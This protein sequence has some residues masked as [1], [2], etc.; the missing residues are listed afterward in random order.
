MYNTF[1]AFT[2]TG[3]H[4]HIWIRDLYPVRNKNLGGL[5]VY[6]FGTSEAIYYVDGLDKGA[7]G[8]W[9]HAILNLDATTRPAA[10][11]GTAPSTDITRVGYVGNISATLGETFTHNAYYCAI[12]RGTAGQGITFTGGTSGDRLTIFNCIAADVTSYGLLR[13]VNGEAFVEGCITFGA[14]AATT[15]L[16]DNLKTVTFK[17]FEVANG[18]SGG[19]TVPAVA[20]DYYRIVLADGTTGITDIRLTDIVWNGFSRAIP[21]S[22]NASALAT[23]DAYVS[24]RSTYLFGSTITLNA[25]CTSTND[26]FVE[27]VTIVPGG[28]TLTNPTFSNCDAIT[29]TATNDALSGGTINKHNTAVNVAFILTNSL[30]KISNTTF[31]NTAGAGHAI[32]IN[33]IGTYTF[34]GNT[35]TGYGAD[36]SSS[37]AIYNNSGG[38]V[39][40]N[41]GGGG[42]TPTIRNGTGASTT[43][44][45]TT[46]VTFA[47]I[48]DNTECR[49]YNKAT[50]VEIAGIE[51]ATAG[52]TDNR[53]F[54]WSA[55]VGLEV[56]YMLHNFSDT[57]PDY[58]NVTVIS[59]I[60]PASAT[61]ID[62]AQA[63]DRN[64]V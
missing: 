2:R 19:T 37:A 11:L 40:I 57:G 44:N 18:T 56:S 63:V 8:A 64:S 23:G 5:S 41:V 50:G 58:Q 42:G 38:L 9:T 25:L 53:T 21:F 46:T 55:A 20:S 51:N 32:E 16:Q 24:L 1:T 7:I 49:V 13:N 61:T 26:S 36:E 29:L 27:C 34:T 47:K 30:A 31:D 59:Y 33:T 35:F 12:R 52:T 43:V 3:M 48:K 22:F 28:I 39:T 62:I 15:Y 10:S 54:A 6:L 60:V 14:A 45:A 17:G 4:L